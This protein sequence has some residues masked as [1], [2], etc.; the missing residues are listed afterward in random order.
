MTD[1]QLFDCATQADDALAA[2]EAAITAGECIVLPTDTVYGIGAAAFDAKAVQRLLDAK[3]RGRD[4]PPPVLIAAVVWLAV[5]RRRDTLPTS[6]PSALALALLAVGSWIALSVAMT[7]EPPPQYFVPTSVQEVFLGFD[8]TA[9]PTWAVVTT[10][11]RLNLLFFAIA[12]VGLVLGAVGFD[13]TRAWQTTVAGIGLGAVLL[14]WFTVLPSRWSSA[15]LCPPISPSTS[16]RTAS[17]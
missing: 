16:V 5:A 9:A 10:H 8:V 3:Q 17:Y 11:W 4:M 14:G 2:A 13:A 1:P 7:R 6:A 12:T 15:G